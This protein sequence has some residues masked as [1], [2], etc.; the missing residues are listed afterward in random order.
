MTDYNP[1]N[2]RFAD[3]DLLY[4][5]MLILEKDSSDPLAV[6]SGK[7]CWILLLPLDY[8]LHRKKTA[9]QKVTVREV[10]LK[11]RENATQ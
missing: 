1:Y 7:D 10:R 3:I 6:N 2:T 5:N 11:Y 8:G 9:K 4:I